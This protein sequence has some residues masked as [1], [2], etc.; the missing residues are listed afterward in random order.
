MLRCC[1]R[2]KHYKS[3]SAAINIAALLVCRKSFAEEAHWT[4]TSKDFEKQYQLFD[5]ISF[6]V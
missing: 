6:K 1:T 4:Q 5:L 3:S 2:G